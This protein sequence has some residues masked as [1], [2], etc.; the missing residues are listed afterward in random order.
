MST[1]AATR[2]AMRRAGIEPG[3]LTL[4]EAAAYCALSRNTFL[5]EVAAG[6]L[7]RP[8]DLACRRKVW[9]RAALDRALGGP[10]T[11][12]ARPIEAEI[13]EAIESYAV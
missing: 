1:T 10:L 11:E 13:D 8:L 4:A 9:S 12:T 6:K 5:S 3:T 7:P 2:E